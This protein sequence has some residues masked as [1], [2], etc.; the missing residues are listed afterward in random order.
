MGSQGKNW[1]SFTN[2]LGV[3]IGPLLVKNRRITLG[4]GS[5]L[6]AGKRFGENFPL[7]EE[8]RWGLFEGFQTNTTKRRES[9]R[10]GY[11]RIGALWDI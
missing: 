3:G 2:Y 7:W 1:P 9:Q 4:P 6:K 8:L 10:G 5:I 11:Y